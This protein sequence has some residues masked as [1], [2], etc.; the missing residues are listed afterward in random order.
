MTAFAQVPWSYGSGERMK[1][2]NAYLGAQARRRRHQLRLTQKQVAAAIGVTTQ[3]IQK[4]EDGLATISAARLWQLS[5]ALGLAP[6]ALFDGY[7][8]S[9]QPEPRLQAEAA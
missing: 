7:D 9:A 5:Q 8:L 1:E 6:E 4:Y 2:L 3:Q